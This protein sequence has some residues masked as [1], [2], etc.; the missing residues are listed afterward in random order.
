MR[1]CAAACVATARRLAVGQLRVVPRCDLRRHCAACRVAVGWLSVMRQCAAARVAAA[2]AVLFILLLSCDHVSCSGVLLPTLLPPP[3]C[4]LSCRRWVADTIMAG[5]TGLCLHTQS[6]ERKERKKKK[7]HN[8]PLTELSLL[9]NA[10][11]HGTDR[12]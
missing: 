5:A 9:V 6:D 12:G 4:C 1:Q 11:P 10:H 8:V 7:L 3:W 2:A